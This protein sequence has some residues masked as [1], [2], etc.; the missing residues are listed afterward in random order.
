M[1]FYSITKIVNICGNLLIR[2]EIEKDDL[3][4]KKPLLKGLLM[5]CGP[6]WT[7]NNKIL[8]Y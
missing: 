3:K 2:N 6:T 4:L 7:T 1:H 5:I 8:L